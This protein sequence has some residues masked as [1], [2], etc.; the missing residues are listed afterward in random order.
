MGSE[1]CIRDRYNAGSLNVKGNQNTASKYESINDDMTGDD[2][3]SFL[4]SNMRIMM[5]VSKEVFLNL[6]LVQGNKSQIFKLVCEF[7]ESFKDVLYWKKSSCAPHIQNGVVNNLVE[8]ILCFGDGT[9]SFKSA[10][11]GQGTY[12]NVVEGSSASLNKFANRHKATFPVYLPVN[13]ISNFSPRNGTVI[14][15]FIGTGTTLIA[16]DQTGRRC[17]GMEISPTYCD[18]IL[19]RWEEFTGGTAEVLDG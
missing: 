4:V 9:R 11:F 13:I 6:G 17:Y 15:P 8:F 12:Y 19:R 7:N 14:D 5:E 2:Y 16:C 18:V 10:Q 3:L 1:M